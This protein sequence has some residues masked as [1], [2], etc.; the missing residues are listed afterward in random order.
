MDEPAGPFSLDVASWKRLC[1]SFK[2][3]ST[4]LCE[5][6]AATA[7]LLCTC[8]VDLS[9]LSAFVSGRLIALDKCP[10]V[11]P[12]GIGKIVRRLIDRVI[13]RVLSAD[14]QAQVGPF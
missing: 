14:I 11:K 7:R 8:Y 4:N 2:G 10:G 9:G 5:S 3:A 1:T 6:I 12:I 13:P